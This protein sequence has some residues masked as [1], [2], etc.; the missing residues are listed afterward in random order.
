MAQESL[1]Q[2]ST[3]LIYTQKIQSF[4]FKISKIQET[5]GPKF[6]QNGK[7]LDQISAW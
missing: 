3:E 5:Y 4:K 7:W 2:Q 1:T 6:L